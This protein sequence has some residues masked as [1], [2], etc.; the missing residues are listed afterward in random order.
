[1]SLFALK[2]RHCNASVGAL[3][4]DQLAH[5]LLQV[6]GWVVQDRQLTA[7]FAFKDYHQ[8]IDF[9]NAMANM[10]HAE[11]HHPELVV[12]YNRIDVRYQTHSVGA[13]SENDFICAAK[14]NALVAQRAG[15]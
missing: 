13:L 10:T 6:P 11:D 2:D 7:S 9:V 8:T 4:P 12:N 3:T 15:A 1:M 5:F 14:V